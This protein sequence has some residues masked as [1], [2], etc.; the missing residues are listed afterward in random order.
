MLPDDHQPTEFI[1]TDPPFNPPSTGKPGGRSDWTYDEVQEDLVEAM[2]M[3]MRAPGGGRWPF[4]SDGPWHLIRKEWED[5]DAREPAPLRRLPLTLADVRRRD[6]VSEWLLLAPEADRQLIVIVLGQLARGVKRVSWKKVR[7]MLD[8]EISPRG[9]GMRYSRS[10]AAIVRALAAAREPR[11]WAGEDQAMTALR[12][13]Y[14]RLT[15]RLRQPS[16]R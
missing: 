7:S 16:R 1:G 8:A 14:E 6:R 2:L 4:A 10:I 12:E 13:G 5:W 15:A 3:W 11:P 9:L